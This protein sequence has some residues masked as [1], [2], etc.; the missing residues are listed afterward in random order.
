MTLVI[1]T[2]R[3]PLQ[4]ANL[5]P[6]SARGEVLLGTPNEDNYSGLSISSFMITERKSRFGDDKSASYVVS[7]DATTNILSSI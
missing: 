6:L 7:D 1:A 3:S 2:T 5:W 4:A